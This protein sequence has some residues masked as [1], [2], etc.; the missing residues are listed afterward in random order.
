MKKCEFGTDFQ[1][2]SFGRSSLVK[3]TGSRWSGIGSVYLITFI[4]IPYKLY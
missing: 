4:G 3:D 1:D 2:V